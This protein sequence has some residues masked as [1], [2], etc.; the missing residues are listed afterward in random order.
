MS[1]DYEGI[2][3]ADPGGTL[4]D[5]FKSMSEDTKVQSRGEYRVTQ[6]MMAKELGMTLAIS[7]RA[8]LDAAVINGVIP[9][10]L[11][12]FLDGPGIDINDPETSVFMA[13]LVAGSILDQSDVKAML[14][15]GEET[16]LVWSGL[17]PGH[18]QN[19]RQGKR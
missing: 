18:L 1:V 9:A 5:A 16:V 19:A 12:S 6:L 15:M 17:S 14:S 3:T 2:A 7:I 13:G 10:W 11:I 4:E 8:K